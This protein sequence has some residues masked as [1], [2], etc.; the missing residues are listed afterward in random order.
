MKKLSIIMLSAALMISLLSSCGSDS[1]SSGSETSAE[2]NAGVRGVVITI[3]DGWAVAS[4]S[5]D[6]NLSFENADSQF[7]LSLSAMNSED[8][9]KYSQFDDSVKTTDVSEYFKTTTEGETADLEKNNTE[10]SEV[11]VC[12]TDGYSYKKNNDNGCVNM[13]TTWLYEDNIYTLNLFNSEGYDAD[14]GYKDDAAVISDEEAA[15]FE[16]VA[17]SAAGGDGAAYMKDALSTASV[18]AFTFELPEG[19]SVSGF[20]ENYVNISEDGSETTA[21]VSVTTEDDL[22]II[23]DENGNHPESLDAEWKN[24]N[25]GLDDSDKLEIAGHEGSLNEYPDENG[26]IYMVSAQFLAD[27]G[28]YNLSMNTDAWDIEGNIKDDAKELTKDEIA[29]FESFVKSFK[30]K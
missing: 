28:I 2:P 7:S 19:Y 21:S 27:D 26:K 18:G 12:G 9:E 5:D 14:G 29:A 22:K 25:L 1:G 10:R 30:A 24:R 17:A 16:A 13:Y 8:L 3:P 15:M 20:G 23:T 6:S 11:K 4:A